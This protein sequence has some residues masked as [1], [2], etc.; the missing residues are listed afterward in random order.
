MHSASITASAVRQ[1]MPVANGKH[2][3]KYAVI[4]REQQ[5]LIG[6]SACGSSKVGQIHIRCRACTLERPIW[7]HAGH[8]DADTRQRVAHTR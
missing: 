1:D 5:E 2:K 4:I 8:D 6:S 7:H 3:S